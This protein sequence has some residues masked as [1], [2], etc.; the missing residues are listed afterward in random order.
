MGAVNKV[1]DISP[2]AKEGVRAELEPAV[3][4]LGDTLDLDHWAVPNSF[5]CFQPVGG[6]VTPSN[7]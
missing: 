1:D 2:A 4:V 7:V 5:V 3:P 6:N